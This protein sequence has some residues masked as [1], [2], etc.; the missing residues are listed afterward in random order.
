MT[1][2]QRARDR[3]KEQ[4]HNEK[5]YQGMERRLH[6]NQDKHIFQPVEDKEGL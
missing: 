6:F 3:V 1:G 2:R 4:Q 5:G